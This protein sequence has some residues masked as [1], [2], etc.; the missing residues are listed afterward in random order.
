[1]YSM[2]CLAVLLIAIVGLKLKQ[3]NDFVE[4]LCILSCI[5]S[6]F[7][8]LFLGLLIPVST[9][10]VQVPVNITVS[11]EMGICWICGEGDASKCAELRS[12]K[13]VE[14]CLSITGQSCTSLHNVSKE[15]K[16]TDWG[17]DIERK[18]ILDN[19]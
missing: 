12:Y 2:I 9:E 14:K 18:Y 5:G 19:K 6:V 3:K 7:M 16:Y 4:F 8:F 13:D 17:L 1:M 11:Q 10:I 15:T